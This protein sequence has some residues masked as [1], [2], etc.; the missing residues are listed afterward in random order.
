MLTLS[1]HSKNF[2]KEAMELIKWK[3]SLKLLE[4]THG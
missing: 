3:G 4:I 1:Y 2:N